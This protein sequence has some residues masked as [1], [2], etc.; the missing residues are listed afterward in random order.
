MTDNIVKR[1]RGRPF[2]PEFI[3]LT[4]TKALFDKFAGQLEDGLDEPPSLT[5]RQVADFAFSA[6]CG[7]DDTQGYQSQ[8]NH[9]A[10]VLACRK[11]EALL[12]KMF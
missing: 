1:G 4:V 3:K 7:R 8:L 6:A 10:D 5:K 9:Q 2:T 12:D 11:L